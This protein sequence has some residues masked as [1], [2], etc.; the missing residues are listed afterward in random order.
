VRCNMCCNVLQSVA[1]CVAVSY[2][3]MQYVLQYQKCGCGGLRG[4]CHG[5]VACSTCVAACCSVLQCVAACCSTK[6]AGAVDCAGDV[7]ETSRVAR[8]LSPNGKRAL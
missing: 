2:R 4:R 7:T 8:V 6:N 3:V 5:D 1:F